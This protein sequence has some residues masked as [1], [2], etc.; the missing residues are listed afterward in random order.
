M[1]IVKRKTGNWWKFSVF[2][3]FEGDFATK[4]GEKPFFFSHIKSK[5]GKGIVHQE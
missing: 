2:G 5:N 1:C 3:R 4:W